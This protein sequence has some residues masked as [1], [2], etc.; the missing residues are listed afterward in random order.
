MRRKNI[1]APHRNNRTYPLLRF[2]DVV[3]SQQKITDY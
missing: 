2:R 1:F 3:F